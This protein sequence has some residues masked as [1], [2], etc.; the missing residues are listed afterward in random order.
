MVFSNYRWWYYPYT[1]KN[2]GAYIV[3]CHG[4]TIDNST[5]VT[6]IVAQ[7]SSESEYNV[8]CNS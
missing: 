7:Y 6:G 5:H 1:G 3:L 4:G 8:A 2:T